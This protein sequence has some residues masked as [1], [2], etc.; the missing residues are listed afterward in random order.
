M[1]SLVEEVCAVF[2]ILGRI[3]RYWDAKFFETNLF[4]IYHL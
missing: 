3:L 1:L 4:Y 2:Q